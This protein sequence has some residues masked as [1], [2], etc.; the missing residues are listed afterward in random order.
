MDEKRTEAVASLEQ[1]LRGQFPTAVLDVTWFASSA[2]MVDVRLGSRLFVVAFSPT[3]GFGVDEVQES[4]DIDT[5]F[6]YS[7]ANVDEVISKLTNLVGKG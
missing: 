6:R 3:T 1:K 2:F 7:A 5:S 4:D